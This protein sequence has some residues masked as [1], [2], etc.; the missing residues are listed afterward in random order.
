MG[1]SMMCMSAQFFIAA[2]DKQEAF[3]LVQETLAPRKYG[4]VEWRDILACKSIEDVFEAWF[5]TP[6]VDPTGNIYRL[7]LA[8]EKYSEDIALFSTIAPIVR[9][10]SYI[11]II[12][13]DGEAQLRW[14]FKNG[15]CTEIKP[16]IA[17]PAR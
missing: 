3:R 5:W 7:T 15:R 16:N 17:W 4:F 10:K 6:H 13:N 14:V 1:V 8:G 9:P 2:D 11:H 12:L